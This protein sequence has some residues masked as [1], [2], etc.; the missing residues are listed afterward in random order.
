MLPQVNESGHTP[1]HTPSHTHH[2]FPR[3]YSDTFE[4]PHASEM[5]SH[6]GPGSVSMSQTTTSPC[7]TMDSRQH[8]VLDL[9]ITQTEETQREEGE[10]EGEGAGEG[11]QEGD[12]EGD[13]I[14]LMQHSTSR[15]DHTLTHSMIDTETSDIDEP[16]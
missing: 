7:S 2:E 6:E 15:E 3:Q 14:K 16:S 9:D 4:P 5:Y 10:G 8:P 13:I 12:R 11:E 1:N